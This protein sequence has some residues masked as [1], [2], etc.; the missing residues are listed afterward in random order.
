MGLWAFY[1]DH[2]SPLCKVAGCDGG[3]EGGKR[4]MVHFGRLSVKMENGYSI[5]VNR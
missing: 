4:K 1:Q 2:K 5:L 3:V